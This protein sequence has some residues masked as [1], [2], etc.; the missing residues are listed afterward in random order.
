MTDEEQ[1]GAAKEMRRGGRGSCPA[2]PPTRHKMVSHSRPN[3]VLEAAFI[4]GQDPS[5]I[6]STTPFHSVHT[7]IGVILRNCLTVFSPPDPSRI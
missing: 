5:G 7:A 3:A 1:T 4:Q 2:L 6:P